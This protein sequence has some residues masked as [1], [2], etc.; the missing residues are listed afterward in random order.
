[1][2]A[3]HDAQVVFLAGGMGGGT[4]SGA[5]PVIAQA[6]KDKNI[7]LIVVATTPFTFEGK[8]RMKVA[9]DAIALLKNSVDTLIVIP[10]QKLLDIVDSSMS[11]I[12][13]FEMINDVLGQSVKSIA[14]IIE[15]PGHINV[16]FADMRSI[17][18]DRGMA[19]MGTGRASGEDR[20]R[21]AALKAIASPLLESM[22]IA[23]ASGVLLN[24]TGPSS[25]GIHEIRTAAEMIHK[26]VQREDAN[27]IFGSVIDDTL[28][29]D[30]IVTVIATGFAPDKTEK[31]AEIQVKP[32]LLDRSRS[33]QQ[34]AQAVESPQAEV[35]QASSEVTHK[36]TASSTTQEKPSKN[37]DTPTYLRKSSKEKR[38]H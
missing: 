24:V 27:I 17:M 37:L 3:I 33:N 5:L 12:K 26:E 9:Q 30:M 22:S 32:T 1:L 38:V 7:L 18:K 19:V 15:K 14:D 23:G 8:R 21:Q 20:A 16:D 34:T 31:E 28:Q 11:M 6:L 13:A 29:D 36:D 10:N 35:A 2:N 4:G 25:M